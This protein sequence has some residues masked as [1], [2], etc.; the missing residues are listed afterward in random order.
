MSGYKINGLS[1]D[2]PLFLV[3][4]ANLKGKRGLEMDIRKLL[5]RIYMISQ[6]RLQQ[7]DVNNVNQ[8]STMIC[9]SLFPGSSVMIISISRWWCLF[10]VIAK[11][12]STLISSTW[13][14]HLHMIYHKPPNYSN[15]W[16]SLSSLNQFSFLCFGN[17]LKKTPS[18]EEK[19]SEPY[20]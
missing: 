12:K 15:S 3:S 17:L 14:W 16:M 7:W 18:F 8:A 5:L 20:K 9:K 10:K 13:A 2:F 19:V 1:E 4:F 6:T 11:K